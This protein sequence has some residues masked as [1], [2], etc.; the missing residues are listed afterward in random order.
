M[1]KGIM[2]NWGPLEDRVVKCFDKA[3]KRKGYLSLCS[4]IESQYYFPRK[5]P[6]SLKKT[7]ARATFQHHK[8]TVRLPPKF[9]I[10]LYRAQFLAKKRL[11]MTITFASEKVDI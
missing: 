8:N 5:Y 6:L 11:Q 10:S 3:L 7:T 2:A 4:I 9:N 1:N